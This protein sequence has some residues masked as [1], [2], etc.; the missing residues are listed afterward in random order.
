MPRILNYIYQR[1]KSGYEVY[2]LLFRRETNQ[3]N[4]LQLAALASLGMTIVECAA[5]VSNG[6][7]PTGRLRS[8]GMACCMTDDIISQDKNY[9][10]IFLRNNAV[11]SKDA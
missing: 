8:S 7:T 6:I 4:F 1:A 2:Y 10:P 9:P 3:W 11:S 5:K